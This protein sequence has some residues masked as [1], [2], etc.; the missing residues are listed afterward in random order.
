MIGPAEIEDMLADY[1]EAMARAGAEVAPIRQFWP[2]TQVPVSVAASSQVP[3]GIALE[4]LRRA[5][6]PSHTGTIRA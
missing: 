2:V 5:S 6:K 4:R 3:Y 1:E